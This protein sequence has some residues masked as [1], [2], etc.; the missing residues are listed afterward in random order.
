MRVQSVA[1]ASAAAAH[2]ASAALA[3]HPHLSPS[4]AASAPEPT[5]TLPPKPAAISV[6]N[7]TG[8]VR[9]PGYPGLNLSWTD[10]RQLRIAVVANGKVTPSPPPTLQAPSTHPRGGLL[11]RAPS[12]PNLTAGRLPP[13]LREGGGLLGSRYGPAKSQRPVTPGTLRRIPA[14]TSGAELPPSP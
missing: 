11:F 4:P 1:E 8:D 12:D 2:A 3:P 14:Y 13:L 10:T 6:R 7:P 9:L 5:T